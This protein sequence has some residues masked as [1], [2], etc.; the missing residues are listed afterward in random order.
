M[1]NHNLLTLLKEFSKEELKNFETFIDSPFHN[2]SKKLLNIFRE[3][4]KFY[5][6]FSDKKLTKQYL[7]RKVYSPF[8]FHDSTIRDTMSGLLKLAGEFLTFEELKKTNAE[9]AGIYLK[10]MI[11]KKQPVLFEKQ[12]RKLNSE[13]DKEGIDSNFFYTKGRMEMNKFNF[14]IINRLKNTSKLIESNEEIIISYIVYLLNHFITEVTNAFL[15]LYIYESKFK[16]T[17]YVDIVSNLFNNLNLNKAVDIFRKANKHNFILDI[18]SKLFMTFKEIGNEKHYFKYKILFLKYSEFLSKDENSFH[19]SMLIS[20]CIYKTSSGNNESIFYKE[21][22]KLYDL[23]LTK[24]LFID[25]KTRY[26]EEDLF[27]NIL[28][29]ALRLKKNKWVLD[30]INEYIKFLHPEKKA[31]LLHLSYTEFYIFGGS[32][33]FNVDKAFK[34]LNEIKD[35]SFINKY[36]IKSL[37]LMLYYDLNYYDSAYTLIKNYNKFLRRNKLVAKK[38]KIKINNFL[39]LYE[40]LMFYKE[41]DFRVNISDVKSDILDSND[42]EHKEWLLKKVDEFN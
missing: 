35:E 13:L 39:N 15:N 2:K 7:Y 9:K 12:I 23:F 14:N 32:K 34:H 41:G 27:R 38:R 11:E 16:L 28:L 10:V 5:P 26:F 19:F 22:F 29:T 33:S 36:D 37:Y 30:F 18:Y 21:L 3:I 6:D 8:N 24:K 31:N 1:F 20:Y 25:N 40:K 17:N 42:L 4:K